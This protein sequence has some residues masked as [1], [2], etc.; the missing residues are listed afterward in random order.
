MN[1]FPQVVVASALISLS[2][3]NTG[4]DEVYNLHTDVSGLLPLF[5]KVHENENPLIYFPVQKVHL[6]PNIALKLIKFFQE[7]S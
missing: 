4:H 1:H 6:Q 5:I 3:C 7:F 2:V